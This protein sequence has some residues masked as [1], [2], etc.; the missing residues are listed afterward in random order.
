MHTPT[1]STHT[2]ANLAAEMDRF[3]Y[4]HVCLLPIEIPLHAR[5]SEETLAAAETDSRL[6]AFCA[7]HPWPWSAKKESKLERLLQSGARGV[8]LHPEFQF[9]APDNPHAMKLFEWCVAHDVVVLTHSGYTGA[10]PAWMRRN[11][12]PERFRPAL[13]AFPNLRL[14]LGHAGMKRYQAALAVARDFEDQVWLELSSQFEGPFKMI[15]DGYD[16]EKLL[17]G[18]D[19][20]FCPLAVALA[21][22]LVA[23]ESCPECRLDILHNNAARLLALPTHK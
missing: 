11:A 21:R 3:N 18:S 8:K 5:H 10:E 13:E 1:R 2:A 6:I 23:T 14:I 19:W 12:E 4:R 20:P 22:A 16:R 17:H 15:L 7:V 9:I